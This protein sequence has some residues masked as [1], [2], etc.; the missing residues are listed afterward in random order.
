M[1][2]KIR[3]YEDLLEEEKRLLAILKGH[4]GLIRQDIV[5]VR[6]GLKPV[7]NAFNFVSKLSTRDQT[8]PFA[9]FG[10]EFGL[11]LLLRRFLLA[12]AGWFTKIAIPYLMKN[13]ASHII[14][15]EKRNVL[16]AKLNAWMQKFRPKPPASAN[17]SAQD[18]DPR[19]YRPGYTGTTPGAAADDPAI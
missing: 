12:R 2:P 8:G 18:V 4:E 11:D 7:N 19:F 17:Y 14:T 6:K 10:L 5:G 3:T 15:E 13:Y 16:M 1:N 9:N